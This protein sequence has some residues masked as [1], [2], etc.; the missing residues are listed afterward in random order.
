[1]PLK[2]TIHEFKTRALPGIMLLIMISLF[3]VLYII[4]HRGYVYVTSLVLVSA[5]WTCMMI[6]AVF[7]N[8]SCMRMKPLATNMEDRDLDLPYQK[9]LQS[10]LEVL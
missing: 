3:L 8:G 1:M 4:L 10:F 9:P 2:L 5:A 7:S 6:V